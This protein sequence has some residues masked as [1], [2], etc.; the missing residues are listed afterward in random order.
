MDES[1]NTN[2]QSKNAAKEKAPAFPTLRFGCLGRCDDDVKGSGLW[3]GAAIT[4]VDML[5]TRKYPLHYISQ[6]ELQ[7]TK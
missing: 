5:R 3:I 6:R 4:D 7:L 2:D 1:P